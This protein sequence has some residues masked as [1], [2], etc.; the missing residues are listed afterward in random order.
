ML[1]LTNCQYLYLMVAGKKLFSSQYLCR[2]KILVV[3]SSPDGLDAKHLQEV[4]VGKTRTWVNQLRNANLPIHLAWKAYRFQLGPAIRHGI[5]TLAN[6]SKEIEDILKSLE[7]K[8]LSCLGVNRHVKTEW[9]R[10][11]QEFGGIGLFNLSIEQFI[12]WFEMVLQHYGTRSTISKK[13]R[14][15]LEAAQLEIGCRGNPLHECYNTLGIL[16]METWIKAVWE[17]LSR[18]QFKLFLKYPV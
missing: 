11:A 3:W 13:M 16:A 6:R 12:G 7:F 10:L 4:V 1:A 2:R 5:S 8:M 18:Y 9:R 15:L 17:Q 14:A